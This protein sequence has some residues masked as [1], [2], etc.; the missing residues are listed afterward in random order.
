[1]PDLATPDAA[2]S[3]TPEVLAQAALPQAALPGPGSAAG[4]S[5]PAYD[6]AA[7]VEYARAHWNTACSDGFIVLSGNPKDMPDGKPHQFVRNAAGAT[8][9]H[10]KD[11]DDP[12]RAKVPSGARLVYTGAQ[13]GL[14]EVAPPAGGVGWAALDDCTHFVSCCIGRVPGSRGGGL[15][16]P[17]PADYFHPNGPYGFVRVSRLKQFLLSKG[18]AG[19]VGAERTTD[20]AAIRG[21]SRGDL[22]LYHDTDGKDIHF[23][24]LLGDGTA[25]TPQ[26]RVRIACHT[27]ARSDDASCTW[28]PEGWRLGADA[29]WSYTFL[30]IS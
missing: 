11:G 27:Y 1:M 5:R 12:E 30:H 7:A 16:I 19:V 23:A 14:V 24:I 18:L 2:L 13:G 26:R 4:P 22:V 9:E 10:L 20:A 15:P 6:R 3:R 8:F 29:G 28:N 25:D 17:T 21:L